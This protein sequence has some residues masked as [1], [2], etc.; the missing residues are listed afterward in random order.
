MVVVRIEK[1]EDA[2]L[3]DW[4][5]ELRSWFDDNDCSPL[6]FAEAGRVMNRVLF[7]VTFAN[8]AQAALFAS[9]F[10]K[11]ASAIVCSMS[12][13]AGKIKDGRELPVIG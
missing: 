13:K 2:N 9:N 3:A 8:E 6:L 11:Y 7:D 5:V 1:P 10:S 4:F 12:G